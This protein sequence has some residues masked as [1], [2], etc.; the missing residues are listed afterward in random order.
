ML[1][2]EGQNM[3]TSAER[4]RALRE[5]Q[6]R[7]LRRLTIEVS[8][9]DLRAIAKRGY[10]G[11]VTTDHDQ[12]AQ[13]VGLF[14]SDVLLQFGRLYALRFALEQLRQNFEDFRNVLAQWPFL[15]A[16]SC[17]QAQRSLACQLGLFGIRDTPQLVRSAQSLEKR[18]RCLLSIAALIA[19]LYMEAEKWEITLRKPRSVG[20]RLIAMW[21][22]ILALVTIRRSS[23][24]RLA[25]SSSASMLRE[26]YS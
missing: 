25:V 18:L 11:S 21:A 17:E 2:T 8:E 16:A 26:G 15:T 1:A 3:A 24:P 22:L 20:R 7:G 12:Q 14:L 5:R 23:P 4:M 6:R 13:A 9:D 19:R 10:E